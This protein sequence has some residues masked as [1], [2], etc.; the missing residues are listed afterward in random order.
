MSAKKKWPKFEDV[1]EFVEFADAHDMGSYLDEMEEVEWS[2]RRRVPT[3]AEAKTRVGRR[4]VELMLEREVNQAELARRLDKSRPY[5]CKLLAGEEN[6]T[7]ETLCNIARVLG[8]EYDPAAGFAET[9]QPTPDAYNK[10]AS[11][12]ERKARSLRARNGSSQGGARRPSVL[13][14]S[15]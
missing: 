6:L 3:V 1:A 10:A 9:K 5:V 7:I 14:E 13:A 2:S 12:I 8:C 4:I 11:P 15:D